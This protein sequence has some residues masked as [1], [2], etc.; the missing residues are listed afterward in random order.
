MDSIKV[1]LDVAYLS[2]SLHLVKN[3]LSG[4]GLDIEQRADFQL[5][6]LRECLL[7]VQPLWCDCKRH[8]VSLAILIS[9][10]L[11]WRLHLSG[12]GS[13][14]APRSEDFL[15][16]D[17]GSVIACAFTKLQ[18]FEG[19]RDMFVRKMDEI[20]SSLNFL[21]LMIACNITGKLGSSMVGCHAILADSLNHIDA[22]VRQL[23]YSSGCSAYE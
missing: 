12:C 1:D 3:G 22:F 11:S 9:T 7:F 13:L 21:E 18:K 23:P 19:T 15:N 17:S 6:C 14:E 10:L 4:H 2:S 16:Y 20:K 8:A 5:E